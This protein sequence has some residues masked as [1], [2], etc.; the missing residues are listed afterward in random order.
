MTT[1]QANDDDHGLIV[2][3]PQ[4]GRTFAPVTART[5]A[6]LK[7]GESF[8]TYV[9]SSETRNL[10]VNSIIFRAREDASDQ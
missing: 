4:L 7:P 2:G 3:K 10:A 6:A 1:T 8:T 5:I 9:R